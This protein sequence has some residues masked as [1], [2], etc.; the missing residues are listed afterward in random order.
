MEIKPTMSKIS[1]SLD[2]SLTSTIFHEFT[3]VFPEFFNK[4]FPPDFQASGRPAMILLA[5]MLGIIRTCPLLDPT[6]PDPM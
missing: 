6:S 1:S 2:F 5:F 4:F 3:L